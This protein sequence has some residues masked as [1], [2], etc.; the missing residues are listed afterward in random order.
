MH[1]YQSIEQQ[2]FV[3]SSLSGVAFPWEFRSSVVEDSVGAA[4]ASLLAA[5]AA[6]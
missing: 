1:T 4:D 5:A 3:F 2:L 6:V